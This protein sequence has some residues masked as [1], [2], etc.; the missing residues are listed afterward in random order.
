MPQGFETTEFKARLTRA[1]SR[2]NAADLDAILLTTEPDIRYF[3]GYLTRF[4]ESPCRPWFLVLPRSGDPIAVIP[5]IGAALMARTWIT[6]IRTWRA[7]DLEDDGISLLAETLRDLGP[8]IGTP[9]GLQSHLRMPLGDFARL[10]AALPQPIGADADILRSLRLVKSEA[11]IEKIKTA[12]QIA[13]RAFDR[14]PEIARIGQPLAPVFRDF[15]R[16]CLDEGADWVPYLAGAAAP[17][18]Y[19]DV[20]SPADDRPLEAGDVLMLDTGLVHDGY[21]CDFDRN[22][23]VGS[24]S[25]DVAAGH[26][27]LIEATYAAFEAARP[28]ATAAELFHVMDKIVTGGAGGSEAGRYGHGLG[29]NLTEWPSLIPTDHTP[30]VEGMVLTLE[31]GIELAPGRALV[32]EEN[33]VI[34]ENGAEWLSQP[35]GAEMIRI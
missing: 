10:N 26:S 28:G 9:S 32:H 11:E 20:I 30:L 4:W 16:L 12:C 21:F 33:I 25:P 18:G 34:R 6:D 35:Y 13:T 17:G 2:M 31:P 22:F 14:V 7:P 15:Q 24:P 3:T 19:G 8:R 1:Q 29:M 5:S 23:S 27:R